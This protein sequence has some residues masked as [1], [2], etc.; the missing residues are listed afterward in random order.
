MSYVKPIENL[1]NAFSR[2]PSVGRRTA[3]RF[4]YYLLKSGKKDVAELTLALKNLIEKIKSCEVCWNFSDAATCRI[5]ASKDRD[6]STICVVAET[7]DLQAIEKTGLYTG[8][9]HILR[10][11]LDV[12]NENTMQYIKVRELLSRIK[13]ENINEIILALNPDL[14]GETTKMFLEKKIREINPK[15]IVT[16]LARGLPMGSDLQYADEITLGSALKHR[17]KS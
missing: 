1:I 15:L 11:T 9:Y 2:L 16:R 13:K 14:R 3:E 5:C 17:T 8:V 10:G 4:V 7:Q 12:E 6:H